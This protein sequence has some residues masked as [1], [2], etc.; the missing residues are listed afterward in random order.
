MFKEDKFFDTHCHPPIDEDAFKGQLLE[1][2]EAGV[3]GLITVGSDLDSS[4]VLVSLAEQYPDV[5]ATCGLHPH[6]AEEFDANALETVAALCRSDAVCAVGE[7]GL[8]YYYDN[9]DRQLQMRVFREFIKLANR[10]T[11][12]LI[13]HCRDAY[14]DC[15]TILKEELVAD[16]RFEIH[17]FTGSLEWLAAI[18]DMGGYVG[19][20][21][22]V[23]FKNAENVRSALKRVPQ[24]RLLLE[25]DAPYLA[26]VPVRGKPNKPSYLPY[27]LDYAASVLDHTPDELRRIIS[28]NT[29]RFFGGLQ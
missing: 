24:D 16:T 13:I 15:L 19:F 6:A 27:I 10:L 9:S 28:A 23:T 7:I 12:P 29:L 17:S 8:D 14:D 26:P 22:I 5:Y 3:D 11:L 2:V 1:A 18:L 20:N 21:G 25:T 4:R